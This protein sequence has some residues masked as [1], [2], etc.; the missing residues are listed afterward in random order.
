MHD[1]LG[2][3]MEFQLQHRSQFLLTPCSLCRGCC[4]C[5]SQALEITTGGPCHCFHYAEC[6]FGIRG[7]ASET[8]AN[9][10]VPHPSFRL[11][12]QTG[13]HSPP[14]HLWSDAVPPTL[15]DRSP[16]ILPRIG[17]CLGE[18]TQ[19]HPCPLHFLPYF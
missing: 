17:L 6:W 12:S 10:L 5:P 8:H 11:D 16:R 1:G 2:H 4:P 3:N 14:F 19:R 9:S 18:D 15:L 7:P 13:V